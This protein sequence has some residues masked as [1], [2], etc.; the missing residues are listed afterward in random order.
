MKVPISW[1]KD[2]VDIT[3]PAE[4][5]AEKLSLA[6]LEVGHIEYIGIPQTPVEGIQMPQSDHLVWD[7]ARILWGAIRE[8]KPHPDADRLVLAM[9]DY[10]GAE[11]EQC[12]TGAPNLF[13]YKG[14]GA[15][16][17][18]LYTAFAAE[19]AEV[20]DGHSDEPRRMILKEK[21][22]RGVPNRSMVCS[23]KELGI[24][25]ED[26][27]GILLFHSDRGHKP[28]TPLQDV[29]G[30]AILD[31]DLTPNMARNFSI[32]GIARE[33]AALLDKPLRAPSFDVIAEGAP[34]EGQVRIEIRQP[35]LNPRFTA[36]L[37]RDV[38]I[39]PAP[40]WMQW[41][42]RLIGQR[43]I[44][45]IVDVT[46]YVMFEL[47]QPLHAFDYD[48]LKARAGSAAPTIITRLP[49]PGETLKTLDGVERK[50]DESLNVLVADTA[51]AMSLGGV[52][53]GEDTEISSD[54]RNVLLEA[55]AWNF[56]NIRR[57]MQGQKIHTD[58][59]A[60]FSRGVHPSQALLGV[61]RGIEL[62][63]QVGGGMIAQG[64]IDE[65]PL[66]PAVVRVALPVGE[67]KRILGIE[68]DADRA[69]GLLRRLDFAVEVEGSLLHVTVPDHRM[70]ISDETVTGQ[71]DI[72][73]E[74]AR[75]YGY[76]QLPTTIIADDMPPQIGNTPL[77]REE[78]TRDLL[79]AL[80]LRETISYRLTTP[81]K[82]A[83]LTP[84]DRES[85]LPQADYVRLANPIADDKTALRQTLLV[86][87]L[88]NAQ[89]NVRYYNR[90][91]IFEIGSVYL[92]EAGQPLPDE[93]RRLG[94]LM[95]GARDLPG[96]NSASGGSIDFYDIKAVV[97]GL[98]EG[99]HIRDARYERAQHNSFHPGRSAAL[100]VGEQ[101][102]GVFGQLHPAVAANFDL[103]DTPVFAAEFDLDGLLDAVD[104][105]YKVRP[106]PMTP[107]VLQDIALVVKSD[108][109][110]AK[111]EAAIWLAGR[112][113]LK[114]VR[115]FDVYEG[116]S[117]PDGHKSLAY[118]LTYQTDERTLNDKE[119]AKVHEKIVKYVERELG[120]K[121]RA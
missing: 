112:E 103:T 51:G 23:A 76:D 30:D 59:G 43:P 20:W 113:L 75:I 34:I 1:L 10:G 79:V 57:T 62:M 27:E 7:R 65:Y 40:E 99:L 50:L 90:V 2:Y 74:L 39:K 107:P 80:G 117:I 37:L 91:Q 86:S 109:P 84:E 64:L 85:S 26:H 104:S 102:I 67:I 24:D 25:P 97:E 77:D 17:Q 98:V 114:A 95:M 33:V 83:L 94:L 46:N 93:P 55:A 119:V 73:E 9:V 96:W 54:T 116:E 60:R 66:P 92:K 47:G 121:L 105:L 42:L 61:K 21:K 41:R 22:L 3:V 44:N 72:I 15:L 108:V 18:P 35:D 6:G 45:N 58:A 16:P 68:M 63:R 87:L 14:L 110:A 49:E 28:G 106:L 11:L 118:N 53:G 5:V 19:G 52:M 38:E 69:A 82:E 29:L 88:E 101:H 12:V 100:L 78:Q 4:V 71:A 8:V 70:D 56:I 115:L 81:E 120:A 31:I 32:Y 111:V 89:R 36:A 48:K 13:E